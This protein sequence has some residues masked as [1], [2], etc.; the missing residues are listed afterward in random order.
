MMLYYISFLLSFFSS[1]PL[2][3]LRLVDLLLLRWWRL[4][5]RRPRGSR[6]RPRGLLLL[7]GNHEHGVMGRWAGGRWAL[8][9]RLSV[10]RRT[11]WHCS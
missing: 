1:L 4:L 11:R 2:S 9:R 5:R 6:G 8:L 10:M 7:L 3:L